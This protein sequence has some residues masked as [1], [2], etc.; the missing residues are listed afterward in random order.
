M[1]EERIK[2]PGEIEHEWQ[3]ISTAPRDGSSFVVIRPGAKKHHYRVVFY[4]GIFPRKPF[5]TYH[6]TYTDATHWIPLPKPPGDL[7]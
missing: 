5:K 6:G 7:K 4:S 1:T 2:N 3:P